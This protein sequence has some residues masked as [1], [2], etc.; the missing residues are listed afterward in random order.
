MTSAASTTDS[1]GGP[2]PVVAKGPVP[3]GPGGSRRRLPRP[4]LAAYL[5]PAV[6]VCAALGV[7]PIVQM[8]RMS[9]SDVG[10]ATLIADWEFLGAENFREVLDSD[11]FWPAVKAT[12]VFTG[13]L[14]VVDLVIGYVAAAVLARPSRLT[15]AVLSLMVFVWALPPLVSGSV[16][17][18]LLAGDGL[19]NS[20]LEL[21][22]LPAVDWLSDPDLALWSVSLVAAWASLPFAILIIR[23]GML[24]IP[25]EVLEAAS[26]DGAGPV[27]QA[28]SVT[29]PL[30]RPTLAVLT[31]LVVL[32]A[33]RSFD[34]V[35]VMTS[36]GPGTVTTTLPFLAYQE[37]FRT[38]SFGIGAAI[39]SMLMVVIALL[40]VPYAWGVRKEE[41]A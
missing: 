34:F 23:G 21:V 40:A 27:R 17:K 5:L 31:I 6:V 13:V 41:S 11:T 8:V 3:E 39:A 26:L 32:Y 20:T 35:Y 4:R 29:I 33:F 28:V 37:A 14:L 36:G 16:W 38:Y 22:G 24:A 19:V 18:F 10:P 1:A 25:K 30:L 7:Y 15:S 9:V 2:S 12:L